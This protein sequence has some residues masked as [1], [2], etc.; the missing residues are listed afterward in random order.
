MDSN[1]I[2]VQ[3][4]GGIREVVAAGIGYMNPCGVEERKH[5]IK[6]WGTERENKTLKFNKVC[7]KF[8]LKAASVNHNSLNL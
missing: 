1:V 4:G 5:S 8:Y 7:L 2:K 3:G 6:K